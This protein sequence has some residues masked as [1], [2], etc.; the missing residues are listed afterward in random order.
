MSMP[1]ERPMANNYVNRF[2]GGPPLSVIFPTDPAIDPDR[3]DR[4]G[5]WARSLE[6]YRQPE[7]A[8]PTRLGHGLRRGALAVALSPARR[9]RGGADLVGRAPHARGQGPV[10]A[11]S[12]ARISATFAGGRRLGQT[13][14]YAGH[15]SA[16]IAAASAPTSSSILACPSRRSSSN[17]SDLMAATSRSP[18][19][20]SAL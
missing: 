18:W 17:S 1:T 2:F 9:R 10:I 5:A 12:L 8:R 14:A 11:L 7:T 6:H 3:R 15:V 4:G 20:T 13:T 19:N 16:V